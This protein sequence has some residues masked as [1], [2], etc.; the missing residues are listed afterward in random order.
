MSSEN[1]NIMIHDTLG[2]LL[3]HEF[4]KNLGMDEKRPRDIDVQR[5]SSEGVARVGEVGDL[6]N[7]AGSS[8]GVHLCHLPDETP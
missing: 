8:H 6:G 3:Y 1:P 7:L 4:R 5:S 2:D